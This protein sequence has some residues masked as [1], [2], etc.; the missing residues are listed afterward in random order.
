[1]I[2]YKLIEKQNPWWNNQ[3]WIDKDVKIQEYEKAKFK[4]TPSNVL[5]LS[6]EKQAVHIITGPRQ[7][8]KSTSL[9]L[10]I[11]TLLEKGV[12]SKSILYYNCDALSSKKDI[13]DLV[14]EY[15]ETFPLP[16]Y[17]IFLDEISSIPDW[18][19]GIKWL[20][21]EGFF[22][23]CTIYLSGSSSINL[24]KSGELMPGRRGGGRNIDFLP[25]SFFQVLNIKG[26]HTEKI[27]LNKNIL[28]NLKSIH[29]QKS[30]QIKTEFTNF[31]Q[32]GGFIHI[33]NEPINPLVHQIYQETLKSEIVKSGKN[34]KNMRMVIRKLID[35]LSSETSY[36][37]IAEEAELGSKN[38]AIDYLNFLIDSFFLH[39]S[40][41]FDIDQKRYILKKNKKYHFADPYMLW[42]LWGYYTG[43]GVNLGVA[44][45]TIINPDLFIFESNSGPI[46]E[47]YIASELIKAH[48]KFYY[49]K[50]TRE[51]DFYIPDEKLGI[52]VKYKDIITSEDVKSLEKVENKMLV[53]KN[54]LEKR[55]N[56]LIIPAYLFAFVNR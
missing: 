46:I 52:E 31:L 50:N 15:L 47:N 11:R 35:S 37:N 38:T 26:F 13:I 54:T 41:Y 56:L 30:R 5:L 29:L 36:T 14:I 21:D 9:K 16:K 40:L 27:S 17:Y 10:K 24:K 49:S 22:R 44:G 6:E 8:G 1:M 2:D 34:E 19:Y 48:R 39:E 55:G 25:L 33:I 12:N 20:S 28:A 53:S 32:T 23:N 18:S 45:N 7:T 51:I 4:F 42:F 43:N 3:Q